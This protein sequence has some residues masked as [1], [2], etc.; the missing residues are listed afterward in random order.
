MLNTVFCIIVFSSFEIVDLPLSS[1]SLFLLPKKESLK[2][3]SDQLYDRLNQHSYDVLYDDRKE[4]PGKKFQDADL[5]GIPIQ[6]IVG[7]LFDDSGDIEVKIRATGD[8]TIIKVDMI[9]DYLG[10]LH[11]GC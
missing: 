4:S 11:N 6:I 7:K 9:L 3:V 10:S 5:I 1:G 8:R 2:S